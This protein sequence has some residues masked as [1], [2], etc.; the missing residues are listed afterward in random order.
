MENEKLAREKEKRKQGKRKEE[1]KVTKQ[2]MK[3]VTKKRNGIRERI[4]EEGKVE[5]GR[6]T[7]GKQ[8]NKESKEEGK[9]EFMIE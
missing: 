5:K 8:D 4:T 2:G 7:V 9:G 3:K 6:S 1:C